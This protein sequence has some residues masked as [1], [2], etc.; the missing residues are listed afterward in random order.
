MDTTT[1]CDKI[2]MELDLYFCWPW[3]MKRTSAIWLRGNPCR[4]QLIRRLLDTD[5]QFTAD[6][7]RVYYLITTCLDIKLFNQSQIKNF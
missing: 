5:L 2:A 7:I 1:N 3:E 4:S 6:F